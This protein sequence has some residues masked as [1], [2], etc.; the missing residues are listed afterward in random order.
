MRF[1]N[2]MLDIPV[3]EDHVS[4]WSEA[5]RDWMPDTVFDA[6]VHLCPPE[7]MGFFS[8][9]RLREPL[10][11]FGSFEWEELFECYSQL[12]SG[13]QIA[14]LI[15]FPLPMREVNIEAANAYVRA[16]MLRERGVKGFLLAHPTDIGQVRA[17]FD[18]ALSDG[19]RFTGVKPYFDLLGKSNYE[20][21]MPEFIRDDLLE[22]MDAERL[23]MMLHT[24]G[25]GMGVPE[26][27]E[28]V[29]SV[30]EQYPGIRIVLAHLGRY[31]ET[32]DFFRFLESGLMEHPNLYLEMSSASQPDVYV[33]LLEGG[34][35]WER[36]LFG[37]DLPYG[38]LTGV[39]AWSQ[40]TGPVFLTRDRYVWSDQSV[41]KIFPDEVKRL[42]YNTYHVIDA[43][44]QALE[45]VV[46]D[47]RRAESIK[48]RVFHDNAMS[49][50]GDSP[51]SES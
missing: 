36:L 31:L 34:A 21:T 22:F 23:I 44:K 25:L 40:E 10:C 33:R 47:K 7:A 16:L 12:F 28:F 9:E 26:N 27:Q 41:N 20:T 37:T 43:F 2:D 39:E 32:A 35:A 51:N 5:L 11:T 38:I 30:L 42:T 3:C 18:R 8:A 46:P 17:E 24:S 50:F 6:H 14:G 13:K 49:L 48:K 29:G 45:V 15:A 1:G 19:V 4:L